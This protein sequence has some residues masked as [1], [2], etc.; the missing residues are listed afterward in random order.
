MAT[1]RI[2]NPEEWLPTFALGLGCQVNKVRL[3]L[4]DGSTLEVIPNE[5]KEFTTDDQRAVRHLTA[6]PRFIAVV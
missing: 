6:D 1:F 2:K 3:R 5:Q 4:K